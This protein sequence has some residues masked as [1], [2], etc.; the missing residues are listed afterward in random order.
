MLGQYSVFSN[1]YKYKD[2]KRFFTIKSLSNGNTALIG[3][4]T[5]A[6]P[7]VTGTSLT[8]GSTICIPSCYYSSYNLNTA[9]K[10]Y[11]VKAC[12]TFSR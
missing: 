1:K 10:S 2:Y 8:A 7:S 6:N 4:L 12:D 5:S 3:Y 11:T 9:C